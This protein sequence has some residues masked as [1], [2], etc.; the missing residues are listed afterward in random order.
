MRASILTLGQCGRSMGSNDGWHDIRHA[1]LLGSQSPFAGYRAVIN[2]AYMS[3]TGQ[4]GQYCSLW[5][6]AT[7]GLGCLLQDALQRKW[8]HFQNMSA[9]LSTTEFCL[10]ERRICFIALHGHQN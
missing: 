6:L 7:G 3:A 4:S 5:K 9:V 8:R 2:R 10:G 1:A